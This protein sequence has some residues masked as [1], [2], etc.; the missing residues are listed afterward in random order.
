MRT[1]VH[2]AIAALCA[3]A[4]LLPGGAHAQAADAWR[5]SASIY[6]YLPTVSGNRTFPAS[7]PVIGVDS[8]DIL[9]HLNAVFMGN[10]EA[11][12]GRYG[13]FTDFMYVDLS[14]SKSGTRDITIGNVGLPAGASANLDLDLKAKSW[15]LAGT[16]EVLRQGRNTMDVLAGARMLQVEHRLQFQIDGDI[17]NLVLPG[18]AGTREDSTTNWDA[19]VGVKGRVGLGASGAWF[20]PYYLD[21]GAG[22]S[23][24]TWQALAGLGYAFKWGDVV[25]AWRYLDYRLDSGRPV[26]RLTLNGPSIAAVFHW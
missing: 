15:T 20:V 19:I 17:G 3:T 2:A 1:S 18:R 7:D 12:R 23:N 21:V 5:F 25:G 13:F 4:A 22:E 11:R 24:L 6:L 10:F 8:G 9:D 26:Q 14:N 16:Y